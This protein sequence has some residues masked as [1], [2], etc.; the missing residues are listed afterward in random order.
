MKAMCEFLGMSRAAYYEWVRK[1]EEDDPDQERME[2]VQTAYEAS[3]KTYG[4]R[5][6][7]IHL[8]Q[9]QGCFEANGQAGHSFPGQKA[10]TAQKTG[11]NWHLPSLPKCAQ[12]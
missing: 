12:P 10:K 7:T 11:R 2:Q 9:P 4:Y 1:L 3:H 8:H 6:I 5:R